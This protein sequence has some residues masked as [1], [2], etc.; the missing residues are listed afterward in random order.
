MGGLF[1]SAFFL[2]GGAIFLD[3]S[4]TGDAPAVPE[5]ADSLGQLCAGATLLLLNSVAVVTIGALAFQVLRREHRRTANTYLATRIVEAVLLALAPLGTLSLV[6]FDWGSAD[7]ANVDDSELSGLAR[8][9]VE[10]SESAYS[11]AMTAL[12]IGSIFFCWT[13]LKSGLLPRFLATYGIAGYAIFALG[14]VLEL[15]GYGVGLAMSIPGGLFE[16][17]AGSFL[18]VKGFR[19]VM[20]DS[21]PST[22]NTG[23]PPHLPRPARTSLLQASGTQA[24]NE[25]HED[26]Q[27]PRAPDRS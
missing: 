22:Q 6:L 15:S 18:L 21:A 12:G 3:F 27:R 17:A 9:F 4:S 25:H 8:T 23:R 24:R 10:N 14:S 7:T 13:L 20:P 19:G 5:N 26:L 2:Y 11:V 16:V 1:I